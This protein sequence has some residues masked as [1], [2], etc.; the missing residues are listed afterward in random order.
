MIAPSSR[1]CL[2]AAVRRTSR[3]AAEE[4]GTI[5]AANEGG[6]AD[7]S[8]PRGRSYFAPSEAELEAVFNKVAQDLLVRLAN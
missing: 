7:G 5:L 1:V 4:S 8:Q 3:F 2:L 6:V